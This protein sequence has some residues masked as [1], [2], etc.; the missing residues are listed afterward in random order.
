MHVSRHNDMFKYKGFSYK[1]NIFFFL[2]NVHT[3]ACKGVNIN[4]VTLHLICRSAYRWK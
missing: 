3:D 4:F 2:F 1:A